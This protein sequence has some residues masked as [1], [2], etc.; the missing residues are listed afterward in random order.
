MAFTEEHVALINKR[1]NEVL[2]GRV[3]RCPV[4]E[5]SEFSL[6]DGYV[7]W[8]LQPPG[9]PLQISGPAGAFL[10]LVCSTCGNALFFTLQRLGLE[11]LF[12]TK[13]A[14]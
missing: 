14:Q 3:L 2:G 8:V 10:P 4:C 6:V 11:G 5:Q 9:V 12:P 1:L 13:D 7:A